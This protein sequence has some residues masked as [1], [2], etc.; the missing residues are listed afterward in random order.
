MARTLAVI[1]SVEEGLMASAL[2]EIWSSIMVVIG[3]L[4]AL[5]GRMSGSVPN[6]AQI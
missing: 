2:F 4:L 1:A 3:F 6:P 5:N